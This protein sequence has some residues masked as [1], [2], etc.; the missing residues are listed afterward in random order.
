M[1]SHWQRRYRTRYA[2]QKSQYID[3]SYRNEGATFFESEF[4][5]RKLYN[6]SVGEE[7]FG[8]FSTLMPKRTARKKQAR[9]S[10]GH[11][12]VRITK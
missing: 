1:Y 3:D 8:K 9:G 10:R 11:D 5:V 4:V 2:R 12:F 6:L 7:L